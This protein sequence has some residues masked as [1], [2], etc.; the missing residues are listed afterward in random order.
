M[1]KK[2]INKK[3]ILEL[4]KERK[5]YIKDYQDYIKDY[6]ASIEKIEKELELLSTVLNQELKNV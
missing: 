4:I 3:Y 5:E 1:T 2:T 6:Q